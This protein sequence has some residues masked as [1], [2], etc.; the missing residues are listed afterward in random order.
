MNNIVLTIIG[1]A[2]IFIMTTLGASLVFFFK[3]DISKRINSFLLGLA[4]GIMV[5]ASIWSLIM[6]AIE[7]SEESF[8]NFAWF[9]AAVSIILGGLA[10]A[11]LDKIVPHMHNGTHQEEGPRSHF[12]KSMKLFFAVTLHNIPEGLAVGFA[13]G[14]AAVAGEQAAFISALGLAIG[15]GIQN[16]PEGAAIS[17]PM[18]Q[19]TGSRKK[20]FLFG[21]GSGVVEPLSAIVGYFLASHLIILQ[22]WLLAFSAGAML[23][24]VA[25]DLIPDANISENPHNGTWGFMIGFIIM[26]I[27]DVALG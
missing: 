5:A 11:L 2:I 17:L 4:G 26:M 22:P 8:G 20:A 16:F 1:F 14:A 12:S 9:P 3:S 7:M 21:M 15:I 10:L 6:P 13:F 18:R 23:F 19:V 25:E 27:L 24:V